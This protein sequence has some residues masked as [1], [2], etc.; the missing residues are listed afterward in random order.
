RIAAVIAK[1]RSEHLWELLCGESFRTRRM[2]E[3][4]S[5]PLLLTIVCLVHQRR[6]DLPR[7]RHRL[8]E[9]AVAVLLWHWQRAKGLE[10]PFKSPEEPRRILLPLAWW[11]HQE[12]K[13]RHATAD[14]LVA[15]IQEPLSRLNVTPERLKQF[16][17]DVRDRSGLLVGWSA[18]SYGFIHL[19]FQEYLAALHLKNTS[20][21]DKS[22]LDDAA[23]HFGESWWT[24]VLL[25]LVS[26]PE[27]PLFEPFMRRVL[28]HDGFARQEYRQLLSDVV[29]DASWRTPLPF[30]E[31]AADTT[32]SEEVRYAALWALRGMREEQ[33]TRVIAGCRPLVQDKSLS[34]RALAREL[35]A[36]RGVVEEEPLC[37][38]SQWIHRAT[39]LEFVY[40]PPGRFKMGSND[41]DDEKPI[42]EVEFTRGFWIGK[43]PVT[44]AQYGQFVRETQYPEPEYWEER[45][46]NGPEQPVVGVD[47]DAAIAFTQ[48]AGALMSEE[49]SLPPD[50]ASRIRLPSEAEWEYAARGPESRTYP[51]GE[52]PPTPERAN[53]ENDVGSTTPVGQYPNGASWVGALDMAGNVWEWCEDRYGE[54]SPGA[55]I[56]PSGS[57]TG[58]HRVLRGGSWPG[59]AS[60]LRGAYRN[61]DWP[62]DRYIGVGFRVVWSASRGAAL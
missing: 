25:L 19:A 56:D 12:E 32:R 16:L 15:A 9:E 18:D 38:G 57:T 51:W 33:P 26:L 53:Y 39:G 3:L 8:F 40:V 30:L 34:L 45:K 4:Q 37:A 21:E 24:E 54:Y 27:P 35:L 17:K 50:G 6:D 31:V 49:V 1:E 13:R 7:E 43:Y 59:G 52:A 41:N 5:N 48:W 23:R 14:E 2:R 10:L 55:Q 44:N 62:S 22:I 11:L 36:E 60:L 29:A 58:S 28:Q 46:F 20:H 42:H 61:G 47:W